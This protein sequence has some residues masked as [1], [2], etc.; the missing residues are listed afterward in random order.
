MSEIDNAR[1][2]IGGLTAFREYALTKA[3]SA[4]EINVLLSEHP[5][6]EWLAVHIASLI[7][8]RLQA[9]DLNSPY[10]ENS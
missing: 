10:P 5:A 1:R 7:E 6:S 8:A 4:D 9:F 2:I 3:V